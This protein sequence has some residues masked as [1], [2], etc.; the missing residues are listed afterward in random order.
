MGEITQHIWQIQILY[1][2]WYWNTHTTPW[3]VHWSSILFDTEGRYVFR[4]NQEIYWEEWYHGQ[5]ERIEYTKTHMW[6]CTSSIV[7]RTLLSPSTGYSTRISGHSHTSHHSFQAGT[8]HLRVR[9]HV[10]WETSKVQ[11]H[12]EEEP[13][14]AV[15]KLHLWQVRGDWIDTNESEVR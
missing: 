9:Q 1:R 11:N 15:G 2:M 6:S 8:V 13:V 14:Q 5:S 4:W 3:Q 7:S 12:F 10:E